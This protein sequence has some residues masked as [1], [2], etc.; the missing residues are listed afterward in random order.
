MKKVLL[1]LIAFFCIGCNTSDQVSYGARKLT[2]TETIFNRDMNKEQIDSIKEA[3]HI[4]SFDS[5]PILDGK[6]ETWGMEYY[7]I[8]DS[9]VYRI[10]SK[11][12]RFKV[13]K[14]INK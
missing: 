1:P 11:D 8:C 14:R 4:K 6:T 10:L 7:Y 13:T 9:L 3:E 12:D 2:K 5:I